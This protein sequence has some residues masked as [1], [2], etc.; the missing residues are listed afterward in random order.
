VRKSSTQPETTTSEISEDELMVHILAD[1]K[2]GKNTTKDVEL[3][4][5]LAGTNNRA[6]LDRLAQQPTHWTVSA[7]RGCS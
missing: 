1:R 2:A 4:L 5:R 7:W 3:L 6:A